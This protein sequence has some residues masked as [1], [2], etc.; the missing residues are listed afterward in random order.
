MGITPHAPWTPNWM[1]NA[2]A[3]SLGNVLGRIQRGMKA[4]MEVTK[5]LCDESLVGVPSRWVANRRDV[6]DCETTAEVLACPA[7]YCSP[8]DGALINYVRDLVS[9]KRDKRT[10]AIS[11][12]GSFGGEFCGEMF[13]FLEIG[14][15]EILRAVAR[16]N[17]SKF[18]EY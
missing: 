9:R 5:M 12:D 13:R 1:Q 14:W 2:P 16:L 3:A 10:Y 8:G 4:P 17:E 6:H 11:D 15:V 18:P 7:C